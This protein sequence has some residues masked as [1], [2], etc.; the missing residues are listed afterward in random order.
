M[1]DIQARIQKLS[2]EAVELNAIA[3]KNM[4]AAAKDTDDTKVQGY[5]SEF[6]KLKANKDEDGIQALIAKLTKQLHG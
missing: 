2:K 1:Q 4:Y 3:E 5:I 6:E